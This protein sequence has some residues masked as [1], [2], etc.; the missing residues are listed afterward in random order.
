MP[1]FVKKKF[2]RITSITMFIIPFKTDF[3]YFLMFYVFPQENRIHSRTILFYQ[4]EYYN[5]PLLLL[6]LAVAYLIFEANSENLHFFPLLIAL[7]ISTD[8]MNL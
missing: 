6:I 1:N 3:L 5:N 2:K 4:V 7:I 8:E